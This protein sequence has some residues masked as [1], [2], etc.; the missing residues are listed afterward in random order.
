MFSKAVLRCP[1]RAGKKKRFV[2]KSMLQNRLE[3]WQLGDLT[4]LWKDAR[5]EATHRKIHNRP[6]SQSKR[7]A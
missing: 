4:N 3:Q 2:V 7:N 6:V 5:V 1:P